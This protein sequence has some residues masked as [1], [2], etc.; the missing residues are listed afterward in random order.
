MRVRVHLSSPVYDVPAAHSE[1]R[2]R[3]ERKDSNN[4]YVRDICAALTCVGSLESRFSEST[5]LGKM[6]TAWRIRAELE[7][8]L[9]GVLESTYRSISLIF[10]FFARSMLC[11]VS[12]V[13]AY[14]NN[15][16][17]NNDTISAGSVVMLHWIR[18]LCS[19]ERS[20][21]RGS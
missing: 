3:G 4:S 11:T 7:R 2:E 13:V 20:S 17:V 18:G 6:F 15:S 8:K 12:T 14:A 5:G 19:A 10:F 21:D 9:Y 1:D 16:F